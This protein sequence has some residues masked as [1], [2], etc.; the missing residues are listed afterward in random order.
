MCSTLPPKVVA[1]AAGA[2]AANNCQQN[3]NSSNSG[4][5]STSSSA[6][7]S[8][9]SL[10]DD[11]SII[12]MTTTTADDVIPQQPSRRLQW[13]SIGVV[14]LS[15]LCR[16]V[17]PEKM[18]VTIIADILGTA[19]ASLASVSR[20]KAVT[21]VVSIDFHKSGQIWDEPKTALELFG[22]ALKNNSE[23]NTTTTTT[24]TT[25]NTKI[26]WGYWA[27]YP[28]GF[29]F[30]CQ[31]ALESWQVRNP[32]WTI[33]ML[34]DNNFQQYVS[35]SDLPST[36]YSLKVQHRSDIIR[37]AVLIR[38]G[39]IYLDASTLVYK[40]FDGIWDELDQD[41][42]NNNNNNNSR[43]K[44]LITSLNQLPS[45]GLDMYN[46]GLMM[47]KGLQ[48]PFLV[49]WRR[50]ILEYSEA[51]ALTQ[52]DMK[53]H[54]AFA[55]VHHH[56]DD[57]SL[58]VL[59]AMVPYHSNL[60]IL[61]DMIWHNEQNLSHHIV[62]LPK[63]RWGFYYHSL[64]HFFDKLKTMT[65]EQAQDNSDNPAYVGWS[66]FSL[67]GS[68]VKHLAHGF[69]DRQEIALGMVENINIL[70]F[71]SHDMPL[72][73]MAVNKIGLDGCTAGRIFRVAY[74]VEEFPIQQATLG[75][76]LPAV[77]VPTGDESS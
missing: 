62:H 55:R 3:A 17:L 32:D 12:A 60:W 43:D 58:G 53:V 69:F 5:S 1:A 48:N 65:S 39:G 29:P 9:K 50:R 27:S 64:P 67:F 4:N 52:E 59:G 46:N 70:K 56:W 11:D 14:L 42:N 18:S 41:N 7:S 28:E 44:L 63:I 72:V 77:T 24:T 22:P 49:E 16:T 19:M 74:N 13:I 34:H 51:P 61:N 33:I 66:A 25:T 36:F 37:L 10:V 6:P 45:V 76:V 57:P 8:T 31:K 47:T 73:D 20:A 71:T 26:I 40:G 21:P 15:L 75:G 23:N 35:V 54:P 38:Y 68:I 30:L 2:G